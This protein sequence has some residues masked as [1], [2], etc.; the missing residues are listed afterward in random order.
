[1]LIVDSIV[2]YISFFIIINKKRFYKLGNGNFI[3]LEEYET[4]ETFKLMGSL[5]FTTNYD[6]IKML[7]SIVVSLLWRAED[8][9]PEKAMQIK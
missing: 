8:S 9:A 6:K 4:K 2:T 1:M 5:G 3:N 7:H